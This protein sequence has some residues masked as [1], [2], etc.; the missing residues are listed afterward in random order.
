MRKTNMKWGQLDILN[1]KKER[2]I[3]L[4]LMIEVY[5]YISGLQ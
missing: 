3:R 2:Y 5:I 4:S 1:T